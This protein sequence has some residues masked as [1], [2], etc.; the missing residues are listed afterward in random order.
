MFGSNRVLYP[1]SESCEL[2]KIMGLIKVLKFWD[3]GDNRRV[4]T[5]SE[6]YSYINDGTYLVSATYYTEDCPDGDTL[7]L[8]I[9]VNDCED[10]STKR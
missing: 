5:T 8:I 7:I 1:V 2:S 6:S 9:V 4:R 3:F 10:S